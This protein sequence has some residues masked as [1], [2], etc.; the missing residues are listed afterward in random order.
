MVYGKKECV[1]KQL[2]IENYLNPSKVLG[3][4]KEWLE[5]Q[6][7]LVFENVVVKIAGSVYV[8]QANFN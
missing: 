3:E 6:Y 5:R 4:T 1:N 8:L 2:S 7:G